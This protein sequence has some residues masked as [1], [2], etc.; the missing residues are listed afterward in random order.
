MADNFFVTAILVSH[1]GQD[2]LPESVASVSAQTRRIDRIIAVD[3]G[4]IDNSAKMIANAGITVVKTDR[5]AG[6]G[7]AIALALGSAKKLKSDDQE[8]LIWILH[9]DCAPSRSA[10]EHLIAGLEDKPQVA[11]VGP[12][13]LGWYDRRH[14]L[15]VGISIAVNGAR[16]TGL[17]PREQDQGQYDLPKEVLSVSTAAM[18]ARRK[19]FEDLGGLDP[20]LA[21]FRDDVDLG[22]RARV[23]GF[24][25]LT[26]PL[27]MVYHVEAAASELRSVDVEEAFLHRPRLLDRKNAAY[28]LLANASWWLLPWITLQIVGSAAIRAVGYLIAKLPGYAADEIVA[29]GLLIIK[30]QDL[31]AA[32]K[33][34]KSKRLL[35]PRIIREYIPP[36][37][38]QIRL[39]IEQASYA[40]RKFFK[41]NEVKD[42]T[43]DQPMSYADIGVIDE[44]F[45][46]EIVLK[47]RKSNWHTLRNRP[48]L[49]G[50]ASTFLISLIASRNRFGSISGGALPTSP[51]G[52]MDLISKY[53]E[54]WHIVGMG[55]AEYS[56]PWI[57]I[58][59]IASLLTFGKVWLFI[60]I[61]FLL[62]PSLAFFVMYRS[63]RRFGLSIQVAVIGGLFYGLSPVI[64]NSINQGR[65]GTLAIAILAP[66]LLSLL[67]RTINFESLSWRRIYSLSLLAALLAAFSSLFLAIW[68]V[69]FIALFL[70]ALINRRDE[71]RSTGLVKFVM[72]AE[73]S[74]IRR[75]FAF[76]LIPA[77]LTLPWSA[78]LII[79]PTRIL[80]EPGLALSGGSL[81]EILTLN[82]GGATGV[83]VW[84]VAPFIIFLVVLLFSKKF[85]GEVTASIALLT[86]AALLSRI[87]VSGHGSS[88]RVWTGSIIIFIQVLI[89]LPTLHVASELIPKLRNSKLGIGHF[90]S[91]F[92]IFFAILSLLATS[93]WA[94]TGGANSAVAGGRSEVVPAFI[95]SLSDTP[96]RPKTL[97]IGKTE[98]QLSYF[99][100]RGSDLQIGDPDVVDQ[101]PKAV[102]S[103]VIDLLSGAGITS[104][105]DLGAQG[106][107][108]VFLK[109]PVDENIARTID[110]I[111]GFTRSSSRNSGIIWQIVGSNSR[112]SVT[113][114][115]GAVT[116]LN[117][118]NIG[119]ADEL[120]TPGPVTIAEN[121]DKG[122][123]LIINGTSVE[124]Q[125]SPIGLPYF[126][127]AEI[128][129][130]SLIHDGTEHRALISLQFISLLV[131]IILALPA[132]RRRELS[133]ENL[134]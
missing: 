116:T 131:V 47:S 25:V 14:L 36:P 29:V 99:I 97:V 132:G 11:F 105:R 7:N 40:L 59:A 35:S 48:L 103:A 2:W 112:V 67:P 94:V 81:L 24:S 89:L 8:E 32:R 110:G 106:I 60:T 43:A 93:T 96:I 65:L 34:R 42:E 27:A 49:F 83:P 52:A 90:A 4:S 12:K 130:I 120:L 125:K 68:T 124:L 87:Y 114:A 37:G 113:D 128:G 50:L 104:S 61:F 70:S 66:I 9:D 88:G 126:D 95:A 129:S 15:E 20:N 92:A 51:G 108:Y 16:W 44:N 10:L 26:A 74:R 28:V 62:M 127:V 3:T 13:L 46:E 101:I 56:P 71:I 84:I 119:A 17:D 91:V 6:F 45:D 23:A 54:S 18:L 63:A 55:S 121:F 85:S 117:S 19:V 58:L 57:V 64:W 109:K 69:T 134:L 82:P 111:G 107:Q 133:K 98:D 72:T 123:K 31:L 115:T 118:S 76:A 73:L 53:I 77:L 86:L 21:L 5:D 80:F 41:T 75:F 102:D 78:K 1:D 39:A 100:T 33:I 22:W 79:N 122:W 30:P 38:S